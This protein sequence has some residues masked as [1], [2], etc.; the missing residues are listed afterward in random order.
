MPPQEAQPPRGPSLSRRQLLYLSGAA[1][2]GGMGAALH[3]GLHGRRAGA[4]APAPSG[5]QPLPVRAQPAYRLPDVLP[6][7]APSAVALTIDDGPDP[8]WTPQ[9]LALLAHLKVR[10]TFSLI[11]REVAKHPDLA[12]RIRGEGHAI[13]NH[14]MS[15]PLTFARGTEAQIA[16]QITAASAA[17]LDSTGTAPHLFRAPAGAWSPAVMRVVAHEGMVPINWNVDPRDWSRPG[18]AHIVRGM[19]AT[20][21]GDIV[22]C[23]DGGGNRVETVR[24]LRRVLPVLLHRGLTFVPL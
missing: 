18:T 24:A 22:L 13:C 19:L 4:P 17:I 8:E 1:A 23:H 10:A 11:G 9:V 21:P 16:R 20:K 15:H 14:T 6:A 2:A 12:R 5:P 3:P 7:A